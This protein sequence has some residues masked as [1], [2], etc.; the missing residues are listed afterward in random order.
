MARDLRDAHMFVQFVPNCFGGKLMVLGQEPNQGF[1]EN[2]W[3]S[4]RGKLSY[5]RELNGHLPHA[6][7]IAFSHLDPGS[8]VLEAGC[9]LGHFTIAM[10][11]R[12]YKAV[13][14]D[15]APEIIAQLSS[16]FPSIDF[17]VGD[18]TNLAGFE[19]ESMDAIYSPGVCEHF[20]EGP[21]PVFAEAYRVLAPGGLLVNSS[22]CFN[23]IRKVKAKLGGYSGSPPNDLEFYQWMYSRKE[24]SYFLEQAGFR[25]EMQI[26]KGSIATLEEL[27]GLRLGS[28]NNAFR[29]V[30]AA[31]LDRSPARQHLGHSCLWVARK[32]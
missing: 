30:I 14:V 5:R 27:F 29:R 11:S 18:V 6:L 12:G 15:Y 23:T 19:D 26:G 1:W 9:G 24:L 10:H 17:R 25:V 7:H 16:Q 13:G 3:S 4:S 22:P 31:G 2:A 21:M 32:V 20:Q 8:R 28:T